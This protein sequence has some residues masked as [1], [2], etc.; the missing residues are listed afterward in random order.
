MVA[1]KYNIP[2]FG[3]GKGRKKN[4]INNMR[5]KN[6]LAVLAQKLPFWHS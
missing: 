3:E 6:I 5:F 1:K 2:I 4:H